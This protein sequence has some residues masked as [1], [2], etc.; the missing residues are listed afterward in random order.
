MMKLH[1]SIRPWVGIKRQLAVPA[2]TMTKKSPM[3][4]QTHLK[5]N[6]N[7]VIAL[8]EMTATTRISTK[9]QKKVAELFHRKV[10]FIGSSNY[11][12]NRFHQ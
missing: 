4:L 2:K 7:L 11:G 1:N 8:M 12:R 3:D 10:K 5:L 6:V 9:V